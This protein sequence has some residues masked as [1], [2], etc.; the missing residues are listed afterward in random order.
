MIM[1]CKDCFYYK[2]CIP[3]VELIKMQIDENTMEKTLR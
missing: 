2:M 3:N 1:H